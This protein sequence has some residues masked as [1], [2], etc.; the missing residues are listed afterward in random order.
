M[1]WR[2][3]PRD[4]NRL[5]FELRPVKSA[6]LGAWIDLSNQIRHFHRTVAG[7]E[8]EERFRPAG[9]TALRLGAWTEDDHLAGMAEGEVSDA[10][11]RYIDRAAGFAGV[12]P[13]Y[14][15]LGLGGRLA[16]EVEAFARAA[17]VRWLEVQALGCD[18]ALAK[19]L[20]NRMGFVESDRGQLSIQRP[21]ETDLDGLDDLREGL[22]GQGI[23][24]AAFPEIDS[25]S[26]REE[27]YRCAMEIE[28]DMPAPPQV[29]WTDPAMQDFIRRSLHR[30]G[31]SAEGLFVALDGMHIVGLTYVVPRPG[32][33]GDVEDTGVLRTHRR[34]GIARVLKM[35]ATSHARARGMQRVHTE[36]NVTNTGMLAINRELG[37]IPG[38]VVV[39]FEKIMR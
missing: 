27:L 32:G 39:T 18:L 13:A 37:F 6:E 33:D 19:P 23:R 21:A 22:R 2:P 20:L 28:R 16:A 29:E 15:R 26:S 5:I 24:I 4:R 25:P 36:N 38:D 34:R 14:R 17:G 1:A 31:W 7:F 35:V 11:Y 9:E 12:D 8:F 30:P 10:G 3:Q